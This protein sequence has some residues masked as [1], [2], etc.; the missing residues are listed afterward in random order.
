MGVTVDNTSGVAG[1]TSS[2]IITASL[3]GKYI[4]LGGNGRSKSF[5]IDNFLGIT[6]WLVE[7]CKKKQNPEVEDTTDIITKK[8]EAEKLRRGV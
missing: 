3:V 2:V 4:T 6:T 1:D 8:L 5:N 7:T